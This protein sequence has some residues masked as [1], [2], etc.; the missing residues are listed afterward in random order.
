[1][2]HSTWILSVTRYSKKTVISDDS[3][4]IHHCVLSDT[5]QYAVFLMPCLVLP[6]AAVWTAVIPVY[7]QQPPPQPKFKVFSGWEHKPSFAFTVRLLSFPG[8]FCLQSCHPRLW[9]DMCSC[10]FGEQTLLRPTLGQQVSYCSSKQETSLI[11]YYHI[12]LFVTDPHQP[13]AVAG[14]QFECI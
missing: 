3:P 9:H 14:A 1:M 11:S 12:V 10:C 8:C 5:F 13:C 4:S 6:V 7:E 2:H